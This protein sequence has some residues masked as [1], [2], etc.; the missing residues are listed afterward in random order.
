L[1][2]SVYRSA[3]IRLYAHCTPSNGYQTLHL[4]LWIFTFLICI[5]SF[6]QLYW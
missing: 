6:L 5:S 1:H 4:Q 3:D 2:V